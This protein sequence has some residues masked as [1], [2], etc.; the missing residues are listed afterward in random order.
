[1]GGDAAPSRHRKPAMWRYRSR[2]LSA[3]RRPSAIALARPGAARH[4]TYPRHGCC[5]SINRLPKRMHRNQKHADSRGDVAFGP[6]PVHDL[7]L[8]RHA[9]ALNEGVWAARCA[10]RSWGRGGHR[11][12]RMLGPVD[13]WCQPGAALSPD[14]AGAVSDA[15]PGWTRACGSRIWAWEGLPFADMPDLGALPPE[16]LAPLRRPVGKVLPICAPAWLRR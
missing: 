3:Q 4:Q 6:P 5:L 7:L 13:R 1:M 8:I 11:P 14:G 12:L 15:S 9:P 10:R 16:H 2:A